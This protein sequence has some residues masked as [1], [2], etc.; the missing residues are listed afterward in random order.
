V[1]REA[2]REAITSF[3]Q[4]LIGLEALRS[5]LAGAEADGDLRDELRRLEAALESIEL[6][7]CEADRRG[8]A[9]EQLEPVARLVEAA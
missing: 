4:D 9:L 5:A 6:G 3:R 2:L 1:S 7:V 8:A